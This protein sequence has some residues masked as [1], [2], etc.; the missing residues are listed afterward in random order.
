MWFRFA[1]VCLA[2]HLYLTVSGLVERQADA[3]FVVAAGQRII[4]DDGPGD[5]NAGEF[6]V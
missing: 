2:F 4:L 5:V 1:S 6:I 3:A